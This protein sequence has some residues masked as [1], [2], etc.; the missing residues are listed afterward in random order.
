MGSYIEYFDGKWR[1]RL[2]LAFAAHCQI[3]PALWRRGRSRCTL[4]GDKPVDGTRW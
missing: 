2:G 3:G 4:V 1:A